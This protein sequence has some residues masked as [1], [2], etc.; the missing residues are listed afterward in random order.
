MTDGI[1]RAMSAGCQ[2]P[3][4]PSD[5]GAVTEGDWGETFVLPNLL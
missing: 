5:E 2:S 1:A 4:A 3:L